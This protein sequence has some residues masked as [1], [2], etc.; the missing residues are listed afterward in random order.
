MKLCTPLAN[1]RYHHMMRPVDED[2]EEEDE[3][4]EGEEEEEEGDHGHVHHHHHYH[5]GHDHSACCGHEVCPIV[6]RVLV[7]DEIYHKDRS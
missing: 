1:S 6:W 7:L 5:H 2:D 3:D 4:E